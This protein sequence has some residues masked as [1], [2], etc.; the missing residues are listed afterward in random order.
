MVFIGMEGKLS[1]LY[2]HMHQVKLQVLEHIAQTPLDARPFDH[3]DL[4][5]E[6]VI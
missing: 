4:M 6:V 5:R 3:E 2:E 1:H